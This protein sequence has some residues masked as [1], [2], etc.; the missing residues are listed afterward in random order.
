MKLQKDPNGKLV[1]SNEQIDKTVQRTLNKKKKHKTKTFTMLINGKEVTVVKYRELIDLDKL[2][3]SSRRKITK[4]C[5]L[6]TFEESVVKTIDGK[7]IM[8]KSTGGANKMHFQSKQNVSLFLKEL[9][10]NAVPSESR[11][12]YVDMRIRWL[13]YDSYISIYGIIC[14]WLVNIKEVDGVFNFYD[15]NKRKEVDM[16]ATS[17][18]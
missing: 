13:Y 8:V 4:R 6:K 1:L 10:E 15:L 3:P 5:I 17:N 7:L 14:Y 9:I 11:K 12:D 2:S 16:S 18:R